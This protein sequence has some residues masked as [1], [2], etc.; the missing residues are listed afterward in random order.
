MNDL[1]RKTKAI[2]AECVEIAR[3][4]GYIQGAE[5][6][7]NCTVKL[8]SRMTR[9]AGYAVARRDRLG[10]RL[11]FEIKIS[12]YF[13]VTTG[14]SDEELR[15]TVTH[16]AAHIVAGLHHKHGPAWKNIHRL[17]GGDGRRCHEMAA[18][19]MTR[20]KKIVRCDM[21]N[22]ELM[23]GPTRY[24]RIVTGQTAYGHKGCPGSKLYVD[25][26]EKHK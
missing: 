21:C 20:N 23:I 5:D 1:L 19:P 26:I 12:T 16:E 6:L 18:T 17:F 11:Q 22:K 4:E 9:A 25:E 8:S 14:N 13:F 7:A 3:D 15:N 10:N 24:K 2:L